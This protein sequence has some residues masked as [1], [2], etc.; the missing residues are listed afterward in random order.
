MRWCLDLDPSKAT[1]G[2][3]QYFFLNI[4]TLNKQ[5]VNAY[6]FRLN[7]RRLSQVV[8]VLQKKQPACPQLYIYS[9]ADKVIPVKA[10]E[11]FIEEQRKSGR[12]VRACNLQSS[13]HVDHFR[14]HPQVYSEQLSNFLKEV[15][16]SAQVH[17]DAR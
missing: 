1:M 13:P 3:Y 7:C 15:L 16:P 9:T 14:S 5:L 17:A 12:V 8:N 2:D 4:V 11:A 10:V 6:F